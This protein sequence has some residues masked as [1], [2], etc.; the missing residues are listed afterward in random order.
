MNP[1]TPMEYLYLGD[2]QT[3][4]K[5][6]QAACWAVRDHRYKCIRGKNGNMLVAF[7]EG[8]RAV[9]V[10]RLLRRIRTGATKESGSQPT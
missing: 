3:E 5:Y 4:D 8:Q 6:R 2:R 10:A 7:A 9:V 1:S